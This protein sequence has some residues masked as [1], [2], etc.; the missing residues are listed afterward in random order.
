MRLVSV[1]E[2]VWG[3]L[4]LGSAADLCLSI[5]RGNWTYVSGFFGG[6]LAMFFAM[7]LGMAAKARKER[8]RR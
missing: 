2:V 1:A 5:A 4:L 7:Q 6:T 3:A 8:E